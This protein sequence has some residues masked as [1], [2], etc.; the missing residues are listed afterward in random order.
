M[1]LSAFAQYSIRRLIHQY[2]DS[3]DHLLINHSAVSKPSTTPGSV[4]KT[5]LD[6][7]LTQFQSRTVLSPAKVREIEILLQL[8]Q[9]FHAS[10]GGVDGAA[11]APISK[12]ESATRKDIVGKKPQQRNIEELERRILGLLG[13]QLGAIAPG[14]LPTTRPEADSDLFW[15]HYDSK[16]AEGLCHNDELY[17]LAKAFP[18]GQR[19]Q[20]YQLACLLKERHLPCVV[21]TAPRRY[22]VWLPLQAS[23]YAK[24]HHQNAAMCNSLLDL[25]ARLCKF[26][27]EQRHRETSRPVLDPASDAT[28]FPARV[29]D[30]GDRRSLEGDS[31]DHRD[32]EVVPYPR[33]SAAKLSIPASMLKYVLIL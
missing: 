16:L 12:K 24:F 29:H 15:F 3:L 7:L 30:P 18:F 13:F 9:Q 32:R 10:T 4:Q 11:K 6:P 1:H 31:E 26:R 25:Y 21:T 23:A 5:D 33:Q 2:L 22:G 20:A 19:F 27:H 17:G 8:Y 14:Q 28:A